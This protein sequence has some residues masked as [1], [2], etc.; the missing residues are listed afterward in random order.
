[1]LKKAE[2]VPRSDFAAFFKQ[3]RRFHSD[4]ATVVFTP[5]PTF[6]ASVVV[7]KKVSKSAVIRNTLRRRV[8][9]KLSVQSAVKQTGVFVVVLKPS[10]A[11]LSRTEA[12]EEISRLIVKI[13]KSA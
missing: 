10:F 9:A 12:S 3:G 7:S 1:M 2:R 13:T 6:H 8:Y 4:N 11:K 5:Y